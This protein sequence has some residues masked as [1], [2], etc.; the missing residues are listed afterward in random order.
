[1]PIFNGGSGMRP[2]AE[3]I[4]RGS[5]GHVLSP[6]HAHTFRL[7][8]QPRASLILSGTQLQI[9]YTQI[10]A[11]AHLEHP[12]Q[13]AEEEE[14]TRTALVPLLDADTCKSSRPSEWREGLQHLGSSCCS[15]ALE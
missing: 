15:S 10:R 6:L 7:H 11:S 13:L 12:S 2:S 4:R 5:S 8:S 3:G 1:M 14:S 9:F